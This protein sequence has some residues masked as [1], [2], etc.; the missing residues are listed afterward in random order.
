[1]TNIKPAISRLY[2]NKHVKLNGVLCMP[3]KFPLYYFCTMLAELTYI[4]NF[5]FNI[6]VSAC[7]Y[8]KEKQRRVDINTSKLDTDVPDSDSDG[9]VKDDNSCHGRLYDMYIVRLCEM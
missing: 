9:A 4:A 5:C 7:P 2:V 3:Y 6:T 8:E 1:M